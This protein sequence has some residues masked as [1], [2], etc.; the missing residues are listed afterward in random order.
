MMLDVTLSPD[1]KRALT[2]YSVKSVQQPSV[3]VSVAMVM[4][5]VVKPLAPMYT[6]VDD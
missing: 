4:M 2:V 3:V 6:S 5:E 1:S